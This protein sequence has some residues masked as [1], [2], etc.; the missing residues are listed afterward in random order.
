MAFNS[1]KTENDI[2]DLR[3]KAAAGK[4]KNAKSNATM[5][6]ASIGSYVL[7]SLNIFNL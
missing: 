6:Y 2:N 1:L 3:A 7:V 4:T 5:D